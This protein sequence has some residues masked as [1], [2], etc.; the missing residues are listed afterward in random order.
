MDLTLLTFMYVENY[1]ARNI[2]VSLKNNALI[3]IMY[4]VTLTNTMI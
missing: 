2:R 4:Y 1:V 3:K